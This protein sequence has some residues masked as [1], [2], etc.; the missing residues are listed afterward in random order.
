MDKAIWNRFRSTSNILVENTSVVFTRFLLNKI[1]WSW[2]LN[3]ILGAR[4]VG[5]TTLLL[6]HMKQNHFKSAEAIYVTLDDYYF[7][8]HRLYHFIEEA[9]TL[10]ITH[11]FLDEVHKYPGWAREIKNVYDAIQDVKL[12]FT[13]SSIIE[14]LKQ[15]ADL[16]RR[17][18]EYQL[19]ELSFREYLSFNR[20]VRFDSVKLMDLLENAQDISSDI[21]KT[22]KPLVHFK[23][24]LETGAYPFFIEN[25]EMYGRRLQRT[26]QLVIDSDLQFIQ[27][28]NPQNAKKIHQLLY[29]L[30]ANVPFKPNIT[31]LSKKI[32]ITRNTIIQYFHYL[33]K[34]EII[35]MIYP[36]GIS[37]SILQKPEKILLQNPNLAYAI[38][39][40]AVNS[41][42]LRE[43]FFVSQVSVDH[44]VALHRQADFIVDG[45][46][47]FE[48]GGLSKQQGQIQNISDAYLALDDMEKSVNNVIPL[49]MFGLLY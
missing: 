31:T 18:I 5:K 40:D 15:E 1:D 7:S 38:A 8:E 10:G 30:A 13:G 14:I 9:R 4:G 6:Q 26:V 24:Y 44:E 21:S 42:S 37:T 43:S 22:I 19:P 47:T 36:S 33:E 48:V 39:P 35:Q 32:G 25:T 49:W 28:Y 16:S 23:T 34:A 29:I 17:A 20:D 27:G 41:G 45:K 2:R 11:F 3:A 46:Y 12:T